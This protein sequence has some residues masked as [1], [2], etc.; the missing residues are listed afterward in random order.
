[1]YR[2]T[3]GSNGTALYLLKGDNNVLFFLDQK[4]QLL[5]GNLYFSYTLNR[6]APPRPS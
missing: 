5:V 6:R 4:E 2:L 3:P 1:V